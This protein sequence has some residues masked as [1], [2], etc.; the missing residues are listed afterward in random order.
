MAGLGSSMEEILKNISE[1]SS[2][3]RIERAR[4]QARIA[5]IEAS[6]D[7]V[8]AII[9]VDELP[10]ENINKNAFYRIN[11]K[12]VF[13]GIVGALEIGGASIP[14]KVIVA[15]GKPEVGIH[16]EDMDNTQ[17]IVYLD[18]SDGQSYIYNNDYSTWFETAFALDDFV[19]GGAGVVSWG[20]IITSASEATD[21]YKLY[22]LYDENLYHRVDNAWVRVG[23]GGS[24][25]GGSECAC[26]GEPSIV[27]SLYMYENITFKNLTGVTRIDWGDGTVD[28]YATTPTTFTHTYE[29]RD[30]DLFYEV[31]I[32]GCT[33]IGDNAFWSTGD[34]GISNITI[35]GDV[36]SIGKNAIG[37]LYTT[38]YHPS[39]QA[40]IVF[41]SDVP[42]KIANVKYMGRNEE[43]WE[44][45]GEGDFPAEEAPYSSFSYEIQKIAIPTSAGLDAYSR[46]WLSLYDS[47]LSPIVAQGSEG[48]FTPD[49]EQTIYSIAFSEAMNA[50][51]YSTTILDLIDRVTALESGGGG[52]SGGESGGMTEEDLATWLENN[53]YYPI[54]SDGFNNGINMIIGMNGFITSQEFGGAYQLGQYGGSSGIS[55]SDLICGMG[56]NGPLKISDVYATKEEVANAGGGTNDSS[57]SPVLIELT[58]VR[59]DWYDEEELKFVRV[60]VRVISGTL[61]EGDELQLCNPVKKKMYH[62]DEDGN[63]INV[64]I[65]QRFC[66]KCSE[67]ILAQDIERVNAGGTL[68][69][70]IPEELY[71]K[72][73]CYT[74]NA[75][76]GS[77]KAPRVL[78]IVRTND[79][80]QKIQIS[81]SVRVV[82]NHG[83]DTLKV[84]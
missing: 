9:D 52:S 42:P 46:Y 30:M 38:G 55:A 78:R 41:T 58:S 19:S 5:R 47:I 71:Y 45:E 16:W 15:D 28:D 37:A 21:T 70:R 43:T 49:Q 3:D 77:M 48:G 69:L 18:L 67:T 59:N 76:G 22:I 62:K 10:T 6:D 1:D 80:G 13:G 74:L 56:D 50:I 12:T 66:N 44:Y 27:L 61:Q 33:A 2:N 11:A 51:E 17:A 8:R 57:S 81:N 20:G 32:Y 39:G 79:K 73:F 36:K 34:G 26:Y 84:L 68:T 4:M 53:M 40:S 35:S 60:N 23:N 7:G 72:I 29:K 64:R 25:G 83:T 82:H 75:S 54:P 31:K 24:S 14:V 65:K 63:K